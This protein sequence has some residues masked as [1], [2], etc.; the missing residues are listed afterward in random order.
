M[1]QELLAIVEG[2]HE[3][4]STSVESGDAATRE[5]PPKPPGV[6]QEEVAA[7]GGEDPS[8]PAS[9]EKSLDLASRDLDFG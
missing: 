1:Q 5:A 8:D 2:G 9:D 4:L 7:S 6:R 3:I